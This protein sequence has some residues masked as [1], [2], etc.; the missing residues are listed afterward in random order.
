MIIE[1]AIEVKHD[2]YLGFLDYTKAV[3]EVKHDLLFQI[4]GKLDIDG[5]DLRLIRNIYWDQKAGMKVNNDTDEY[6]NIKNRGGGRQS[7]ALSSDL[8]SIYDEMILRNL[9]E[10]EGVKIGGCNYV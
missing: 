8:F 3:N 9:E 10:I 4:L 6:I 5:K 1:R 2:I 7:C